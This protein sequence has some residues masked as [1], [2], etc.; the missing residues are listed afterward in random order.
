M[1]RKGLNK[2]A[3]KAVDDYWE[4][5]RIVGEDDG[6]NLF[7]PEQYEEYR[8]KVLPQRVQNRLYVSFGVPGGAD[9]KQIGPETQCFCTHRF[10]PLV[11]SS[12][13][14]CRC[15]H[16]LQD[17]RE[18]AAH[19]CKKCD[20]CSGFQSPYTCGCG[21]P[22]YAHQTLVETK[23]ERE[24]RG[25]PAGKGVPYAAMGGLTGFRS[26]LDGYL[27]ME[28]SS[29]EDREDGCVQT[30]SA[31]RM[32]DGSLKASSSGRRQHRSSQQ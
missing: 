12:P 14:R 32:S 11:G 28:A 26:L 13:V 19:L 17:H 23:Q 5:T 3:L 25:Q 10:V 27:N 31:S 16:Q 9:C 20:F 22:C 29:E 30:P 21:Q 6:G 4:Y 1:A 24:A 18:D 7:T 8:R 15:K 2:S